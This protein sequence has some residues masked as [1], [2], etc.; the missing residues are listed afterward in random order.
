MSI[1][2]ARAAILAVS[3]T[4]HMSIPMQPTIEAP[5]AMFIMSRPG[6]ERAAEERLPLSLPNAMIEPVAVV[7]PM[8]VARQMA[9]CAHER[10]PR[11]AFRGAAWT[12][13]GVRVRAGVERLRVSWCM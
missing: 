13:W 12:D 4:L 8:T 7:P 6:R 2:P 3:L 5:A 9:P 11:G 1:L 10:R